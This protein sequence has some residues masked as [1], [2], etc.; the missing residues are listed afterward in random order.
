MRYA[1]FSGALL[2]AGLC[3]AS[4]PAI[5]QV[6]PVLVTVDENGHGSVDL[7]GLSVPLPGVLMADPGPGGL[8]ST[9]TYSL[10]GTPALIAGDVF[11]L[12]GAAGGGIQDVIRFNPAGTG[13]NPA[14]PPSLVFY[15]DNLGGADDLA[16][17]PSPPTSFYTNT[18]TISEVGPEGN[19]GAFYTPTPNQPGFVPGFAVSYH[20]ISDFTPVPEPA[21]VAFLAASVLTGA[22]CLRR[23]RKTTTSA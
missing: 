20:F 14:Y 3:A 13:G 22:A 7:L 17:T 21:S 2:L 4:M 11:L 9:L 16:D 12:E 10:A 18:V 15:S 5:A 6:P 8:S 1:K 19:N 23:R